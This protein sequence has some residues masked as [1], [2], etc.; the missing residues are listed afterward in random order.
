MNEELYRSLYSKY[1][2]EITEA[3]LEKKIEYATS[4]DSS[5][6]VNSF[7]QKYTSKPPTQDQ[8]DYISTFK[9][10]PGKTTDPAVAEPIVGSE[11]TVS[12]GEESS[13]ESVELGK[14]TPSN[15]VDMIFGIKD[16][17]KKDDEKVTSRAAEKYFDLSELNRKQISTERVGG[18][19]DGSRQVLI[20]TRSIKN[21]K[22]QVNYLK[23]TPTLMQK[24]FQS[25]LTGKGGWLS[26]VCLTFLRKKEQRLY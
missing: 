24:L 4:I 16:S 11:N 26:K 3:E 6:F 2:P 12:T 10:E 25:R 19:K 21:T 7:Y 1:A 8:L 20:N 17:V 15:Y 23:T 13:M 5:E 14:E 22:K 18:I 9:V